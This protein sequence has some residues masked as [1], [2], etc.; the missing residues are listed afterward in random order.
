MTPERSWEDKINDIQR[1]LG[2]PPLDIATTTGGNDND[3][4]DAVHAGGAPALD[5]SCEQDHEK[6]Q[7]DGKAGKGD[8]KDAERRQ[9]RRRDYLVN[10]ARRCEDCADR[11]PG[12][13]KECTDYAIRKIVK[14]IAEAE[15]RKRRQLKEDLFALDERHHMEKWKNVKYDRRHR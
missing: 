9:P 12:C 15:G 2:K 4:K 7:E 14:V 11:K 5:K 3:D 6:L 13:D 1:M 8:G 10:V